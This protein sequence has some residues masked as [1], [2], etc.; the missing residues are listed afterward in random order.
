MTDGEYIEMQLNTA[1]KTSAKSRWAMFLAA[2]AL[3]LIIGVSAADIQTKRVEQATQNSVELQAD[4]HLDGRGKWG[5][6]LR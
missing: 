1:Q 2:F 4:P 6:Y 3:A 5:G